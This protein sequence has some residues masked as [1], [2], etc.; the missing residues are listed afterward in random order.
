MGMSL[1]SLGLN[2]I[3][4][5]LLGAVIFYARRLS[6]S[7]AIFRSS[8]QEMKELIK[9]LSI[10]VDKAEAAIKA[11]R[12]ETDTS[13]D[14]LHFM[15]TKGKALSEELQFIQESG[16][17]LATRLEK[18]SKGTKAEQ[19]TIAEEPLVAKKPKSKDTKKKSPPQPIFNIIDREEEGQIGGTDDLPE[20]LTEDT[21]IPS[22]LQSQAEKDLAMA[23]QRQKK[24]KKG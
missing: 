23:L 6:E 20:F 19:E 12:R 5:I 3:L 1:L 4:M 8:R 11:M 22:E 2:V 18:A 10:N 21:D 17:R 24:M 9:D 16:D 13:A 15:I 14:D 7:I